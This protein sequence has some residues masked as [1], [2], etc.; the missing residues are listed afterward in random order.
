[1]HRN[2]FPHQF[3]VRG[4]LYLAVLISPPPLRALTPTKEPGQ[5][6]RETAEKRFGGEERGGGS[7]RV[8]NRSAAAMKGWSHLG[9]VET[10]YEEEDDDDE[11][12]E[13]EEEEEVEEESPL[14]SSVVSPASVSSPF[15][16]SS[17]ISRVQAWSVIEYSGS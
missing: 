13:G 11:E 4:N 5:K 6:R 9:A 2:K 12:E 10:I 3:F 14:N 8:Y 17:L 7:F 16:S 1:M 15:T